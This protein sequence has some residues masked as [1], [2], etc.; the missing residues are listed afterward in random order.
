M[1]ATATY[2]PEDNKLRL[3][4]SS[5]LSEREY[6]NAKA[7]GF[8]WAPAHELFFATWSPEAEDFATELAGEVTDEDKTLVERAE[9]RAERF[10][11]YS[12]SR[13]SE[14]DAAHDAVSAIVNGIPL[15]QPIL[16]GHHSEKR[17]RRDAE[18]IENG[19]R[20]ALSCFETA[21]YW[22]SRAKGAIRA[23]KYKELPAVRARRIKTLEAEQRKMERQ[24]AGIASARR[25]WTGKVVLRH[26]ETGETKPA[27]I[28]E[29]NRDLIWRVLGSSSN[30]NYPVAGDGAQ[31]WTA[32]DVL[33]PATEGRWEGAP[34]MTVAEVAA[35]C[36]RQVENLE[37]RAERWRAHYAG[38]LDY[39]RAMLDEAGGTVADQTKPEKGGACRCWASPAGG[40][41][42]IQKVN[43]VS[44]T[45]LD[46]WGN[47]GED[48]TRVIPFDKLFAVMSKAQVD[49][50]R[51]E[52]RI[53]AETPRGFGLTTDSPK[54]RPTTAPDETR[55]KANGLR[56]ALRAGVQVVA[57]NQLFPTP[58]ELAARM[59]AMAEIRPGMT[60]LEPSAGTG[61]LLGA[62]PDGVQATAIEI[63][64]ALAAGLRDRFQALRDAGQMAILQGDFLATYPDDPPTGLGLFDRVVMNPPF[65]NAADVEH[66]LRAVRFLKPGGRLVALCAAGPRQQDALGGCGLG[67]TWEPLG[68]GLFEGTGVSVALVTFTAPTP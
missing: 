37:A 9:E 13:Q 32:W 20:R 43:R 28:T 3:Y 68:A 48:F 63:N 29:E 7:A 57:A 8:R 17:A 5:R 39:E 56:T 22:K 18:R 30:G 50:A 59:V 53:I 51:A 26:R 54:P 27:E 45:L 12:E 31:S 19:M 14:G 16:V 62:L 33:R 36:L 60:V 4:V 55:E 1:Q 2:S 6:N 41:S 42:I 11:T 46:N 44:V 25:L 24:L 40:W 64:Q 61:R 47:G 52:G 38:R 49:A 67:A 66:I 10:T 34:E 65:E 58:P 23:A 15:G 21:E 35:K